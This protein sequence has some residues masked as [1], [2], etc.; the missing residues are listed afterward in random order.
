MMLRAAI[1]RAYGKGVQYHWNVTPNGRVF[2]ASIDW[3]PG[4]TAA[5]TH[6]QP[7][8][9]FNDRLA[10]ACDGRAFT[11]EHLRTLPLSMGRGVEVRGKGMSASAI[12]A[13]ALLPLTPTPFSASRSG[14]SLPLPET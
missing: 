7:A 11:P 5:Q 1:R 4:Q 3:V 6:R 12:L 9:H 13:A 10:A 14:F 8:P 2:L